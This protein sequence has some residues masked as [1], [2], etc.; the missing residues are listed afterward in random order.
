MFLFLGLLSIP[1]L[2]ILGCYL[3]IIH[4]F[5]LFLGLLSTASLN[6]VGSEL[7]VLHVFL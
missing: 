7:Y 5:Y 3:D 6:L 2:G 1:S 4:V